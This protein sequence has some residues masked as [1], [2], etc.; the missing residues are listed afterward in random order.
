MNRNSWERV[1]KRIA[2]YLVAIL[3]FSAVIIGYSN[4]MI[5]QCMDTIN[6]KNGEAFNRTD[7]ELSMYCPIFYRFLSF[8]LDGKDIKDRIEFKNGTVRVKLSGLAP[9]QHYFQV[10]LR[11]GLHPVQFELPN[12]CVRFEIDNISPTIT[13]ESPRGK[14]IREKELYVSGKTEPLINC[15]ISINGKR[16]S[17]KSDSMGNFYHKI[18]TDRE[19]NNLGIIAMDRAGNKGKIFKVLILDET[20]PEIAVEEISGDGILKANDLKISARITDTG[21][22]IR[23]CYFEIEDEL[24]IGTYNGDTGEITL[25]LENLDE[26][27]YVVKVVAKDKAGWKSEKEQKFIVDSVE[28]LGS[29]RVR[30]GA[31]GKDVEVI[32][33]K[34]IH[35]GFLGKKHVSGKYDEHT[36]RAIK[37][38]QK[39]R[40]LSITGILD[41]ETF[42]AMSEK[43]FVYLN[44]FSLALIS[45]D[46]KI[47]KTYPIACGSPYYPTPSGEYFVREK[48]YYPAWYPPNSPWAKG[49][50][51]VPPGPG[52]PLGTRWIGLNANIVGIH[53]TPSSWSI[54]SAS[55]HGCI[56]MYISDVEELF[57]MVNIGT[58]VT[59]YPSR[60]DEHKKFL[61]SPSP[62]KSIE[63]EKQS[64]IDGTGRIR[65]EINTGADYN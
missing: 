56:R 39:L 8:H 20:P 14:L 29:N 21:S 65:G 46:G 50:K 18:R 26:G 34:L 48:V 41:R 62:E 38:M 53:G 11:R 12:R 33:K 35:L 47:M 19:L 45:P 23:D 32:Q 5:N 25:N 10:D 49:A 59:I 58:P 7:I 43:I 30:P 15:S 28:E 6:I 22:G 51:P 54:G 24:F 64:A 4:L 44:E 57:E 2:V 63:K 36:T 61:S 27:E 37:E 42:L 16:H 3:I 40:N 1:K 9:G 17:I 52:N 31:I 60:P 55:S 13:L